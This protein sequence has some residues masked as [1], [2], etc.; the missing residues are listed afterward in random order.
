[1]LAIGR[2]MM[3]RPR[4]LMLDEPSMGL[5]P[6]MMQRIM[7]TIATLQAEGVTILLVEQ[8]AAA[9]LRLADQA[10]VLEVGQITLNGTGAQ[11]LGDDRVKRAYL[12]ED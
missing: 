2:A 6:L 4:L 1:M 8:N 9:A 3:S 11:L 7:A 12:G 10:Y 5:S